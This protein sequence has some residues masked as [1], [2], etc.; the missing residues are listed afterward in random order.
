MKKRGLKRRTSVVPDPD[1]PVRHRTVTT[2]LTLPSADAEAVAAFQAA[3]LEFN[4]DNRIKDARRRLPQIVGLPEH[5]AAAAWLRRA[6]A[7]WTDAQNPSRP[8]ALRDI[9][10]GDGKGSG[11]LGALDRFNEAISKGLLR[12]AIVPNLERD[13]ERQ[14]G[15]SEGGKARAQNR[16]DELAV[17]DREIVAKRTRMI[18][19][20]SEKHDIAGKLAGTEP[21][22]LSASTL[23]RIFKKAGV[24]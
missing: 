23:R 24:S 7:Y 19:D 2:T 15:A 10:A 17:R 22:R 4:V 8:L 3:A 11:A 21:Y 14:V 13:A 9:A 18:L 16:R 6:K 20:G 12:R 5:A 1:Y